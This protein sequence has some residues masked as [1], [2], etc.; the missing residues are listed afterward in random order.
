MSPSSLV[1]KETWRQA[2]CPECVPWRDGPGQNVWTVAHGPVDVAARAPRLM[3]PFPQP[4]L[5]LQWG[6]K[7]TGV[8]EGHVWRG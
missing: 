8:R 1:A 4:P 2:A 6:R 5:G 7:T 3:A